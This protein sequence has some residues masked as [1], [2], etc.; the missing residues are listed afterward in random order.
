MGVLPWPREDQAVVIDSIAPMADALRFHGDTGYLY[1]I[2]A[3][4][5]HKLVDTVVARC[6]EGSSAMEDI[7][8]RLLEVA[9]LY[10]RTEA[11]QTSAIQSATQGL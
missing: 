10:E 1:P 11:R 5:Y 2:F 9:Q 6:P 4:A 8:N 3:P 7:R